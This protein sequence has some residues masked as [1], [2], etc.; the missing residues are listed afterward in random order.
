M[1]RFYRSRRYSSS[2]RTVPGSTRRVRSGPTR[3]Y[4]VLTRPRLTRKLVHVLPPNQ[5]APLKVWANDSVSAP[6][7][8]LIHLNPIA[9]GDSIEKRTANR[10]FM[11]NLIICG[12]FLASVNGTHGS[13]CARL[14][15]VYD[16]RPTSTLPLVNE[17]F[18]SGHQA[19][20]PT[21]NQRDR[22]EILYNRMVDFNKAAVVE[23]GGLRFYQ[24]SMRCFRLVIPVNRRTTFLANADTGTLANTVT[25]ALYITLFNEDDA[26]DTNSHIA[27]FHRLTFEDYA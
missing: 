10:V 7:P 23:T 19:S 4:P 8:A 26:A 6:Y 13:D 2:R 27:F 12:Q 5:T 3:D 15:L 16:R 9:L 21:L 25:G 1:P 22:F 20:F 14:A 17:I 11:R 24:T 18:D